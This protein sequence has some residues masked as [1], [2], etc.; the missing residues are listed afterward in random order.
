MERRIQ[1]RGL[2]DD[3]DGQHRPSQEEALHPVPGAACLWQDYLIGSGCSL[4]GAMPA[5]TPKVS[6]KSV[7]YREIRTRGTNETGWTKHEG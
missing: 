2:R 6:L 3:E 7:A 1:E 5:S 4:C